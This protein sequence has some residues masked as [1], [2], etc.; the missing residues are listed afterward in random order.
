[1]TGLSGYDAA[2]VAAARHLDLPLV[3]ADAQIKAAAKDG[4]LMLGDLS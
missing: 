1:V 2:F 3:T 4:V